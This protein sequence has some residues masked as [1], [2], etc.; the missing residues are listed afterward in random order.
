MFFQATALNVEG[1][2]VTAQA[3]FS[4]C[5][6]NLY[7]FH[8]RIFISYSYLGDGLITEIQFI[9]STLRELLLRRC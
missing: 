6:H 1:K 9:I 5:P 3:R 2:N 8:F 4:T 7:V